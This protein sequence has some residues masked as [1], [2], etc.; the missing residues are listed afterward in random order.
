MAIEQKLDLLTRIYALYDTFAR[1]LKV[2]CRKY[3]AQCCTLNV[4]LTTLEGYHLVRGLEPERLAVLCGGLAPARTQ[5]SFRPRLT[6]NRIAALCREGREIPEEAYGTSGDSCPLLH[7][8]ICRVYPLRP[9][10]CRCFVSRV[11]C[12]ASGSA[13]VPDFVLTVN[14]VFIQTIEH[15][16]AAGCTGNLTDVLLCLQAEENQHAYRQDRLDCSAGGLIG[17]H[18]L[19]AL[20]V[21]PEHRNRLQPIL[22]ALRKLAGGPS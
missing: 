11:A 4:S 7:D 16:D 13:E 2:A 14:T 3:C 18:H 10:G 21:P 6:T 1:G 17:N 9:F 5:P 12:R 20:M 8:A 19:T 15:L 22:G